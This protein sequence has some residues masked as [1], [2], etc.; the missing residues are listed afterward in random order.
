MKQPPVVPNVNGLLFFLKDASAHF[1]AEEQSEI[2]Q[3]AAGQKLKRSY[4]QC[5][6]HSKQ[7]QNARMIYKRKVQQQ[8]SKSEGM[9]DSWKEE[10]NEL[11]HQMQVH[12]MMYINCLTYATCPREW[13]CYNQ[14]WGE[15]SKSVDIQEHKDNGTLDWICRSE[16]L[17]IERCV[18]NTVA[19]AIMAGD[20][21]S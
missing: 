16:R 8:L 20:L 14:C 19:S 10:M 3:S 4:D 18:G 13:K 5:S 2:A 7:M 6:G 17:S 15:N 12:E 11:K 21:S 9:S 1:S